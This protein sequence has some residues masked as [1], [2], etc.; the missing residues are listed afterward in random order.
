MTAAIVTVERQALGALLPSGLAR[1]VRSSPV[2]TSRG[3]AEEVATGVRANSGK[4]DAA[5][6]DITDVAATEALYRCVAA[7]AG[8]STT[9]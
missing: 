6:L 8:G 2:Q 9:P 7:R 3:L 5:I 1:W 4:A